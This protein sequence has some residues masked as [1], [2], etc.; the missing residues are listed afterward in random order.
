MMKPKI[1]V[2]IVD[3]SPTFRRL[4]VKGLAKYPDISVIG[5]ASNPYEAR[6][7]ILKTNPDVIT[8]DL[9]MPKMGGLEFISILMKHHPIP[10]VIVSSFV[11][12]K[13][14]NSLK[15]LELGAIDV[16]GKPKND[17]SKQLPFFQE[18]LYKKIL[19]GSLAKVAGS[20]ALSQHPPGISGVENN[21]RSNL[22]AI[23]A[24]TG[25]VQALKKI[26]PCFP[27]NSPPIIITQ[28][29][30]AEFTAG[31]AHS[32]NVLCPNIEVREA[33]NGD[34]L[35]NGLAVIAP[36]D[37]HLLLSKKIGAYTVLVKHGPKV[38]YQRPSVDVMFSSVA[39]FA[40]KNATGI[41]L[42]GMGHDGAGGLLKMKRQGAFTIAESEK[43][44]VVHGMPNAAVANGAV[45][46]V[47]DLLEIPETI[48]NPQNNGR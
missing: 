36:G 15:A 47:R 27:A 5:Q 33:Q 19:A 23:G 11:T 2:L 37:Y 21:T 31:F 9:E 34:G 8:L 38:C 40:G 35:R 29:M 28:H 4:L 44:C 26:L 10:I 20:K 6:E 3:D 46:C 22:I 42:T 24:S 7:I 45:D 14:Q 17:S 39:D 30:P 16:V 48:F 43:T 41:I 32:L 1:K 12:G 25:G 13:C 18:E